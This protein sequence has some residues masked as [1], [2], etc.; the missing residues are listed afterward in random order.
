[1]FYSTG[2]ARPQ[3][4]PLRCGFFLLE[5]A[6][7]E[8]GNPRLT[9][10]AGRLFRRPRRTLGVLLPGPAGREYFKRGIELKQLGAD[11]L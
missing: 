5:F 3:G 2:P 11:V 4:F 6:P 10:A 8:Q 7:S 1:M 9:T